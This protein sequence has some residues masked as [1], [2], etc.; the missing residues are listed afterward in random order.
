MTLSSVGVCDISTVCGLGQGGA[1]GVHLHLSGPGC[2]HA[3]GPG[4]E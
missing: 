4:R 2:C 1:W 3:V